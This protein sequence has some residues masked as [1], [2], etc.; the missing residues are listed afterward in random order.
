MSVIIWYY[1]LHIHIWWLEKV[2][3]S[4]ETAIWAWGFLNIAFCVKIALNEKQ[5][6]LE[7]TLTYY[8]FYCMKKRKQINFTNP[9]KI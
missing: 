2:I 5:Y 1:H 6:Y 4:S 3:Y 8:I 7:W 9:S